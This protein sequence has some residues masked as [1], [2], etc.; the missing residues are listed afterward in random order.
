[1][2]ERTVSDAAKLWIKR[3]ELDELEQSTLRSYRGQV[4]H[5][6]LPKI[7]SYVLADL[8]RSDVRD[9]LDDMLDCA[10]R[11]MTHKVLTSLRSLLAEAVEREWIEHNVARDVKLRTNKRRKYERVIPTKD[12]IKLLLDN[13]SPKEEPMF[14]TIIF[15]GMRLSEVRG[16]PWSNVD[17][18]V[19]LI[20]VT[21]RADENCV[22]GPPKSGAGIR[23]IPLAPR[24]ISVLKEWKTKCPKGEHDLVFPNGKG[25][26]ERSANIHARRFQPMMRRAGL[27]DENGKPLFNIHALR[28]AAAS[29]FLDQG[30]QMKKVQTMLGHSSITM[31]MDVYGHLIDDVANDVV[32]FEKLEKDLFS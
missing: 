3:C 25:N 20:K 28:H 24:V 11:A 22:I 27:V 7:G 21:Q 1:M 9:F 30:W 5:H 14:V 18:D 4:K 26:I 32:L 23:K 6:I 2:K 13:M 12:Q 10:S 19:G 29:L 8:K 31:T 17:L 16:L 15:T